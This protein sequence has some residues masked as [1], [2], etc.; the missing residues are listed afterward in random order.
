[1]ATSFHH[2]LPASSHGHET[3]R[4]LLALE[5]HAYTSVSLGLPQE[6]MYRSHLLTVQILRSAG[7]DGVIRAAV[8][9]VVA[10][11][12]AVRL[13]TFKGW[14][15]ECMPSDKGMNNPYGSATT[16]YNEARSS[17][18]VQAGNSTSIQAELPHLHACHG[19]MTEMGVWLIADHR[20]RTTST[21]AGQD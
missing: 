4:S 8:A 7:P 11:H 21:S 20:A 17:E 15:R 5:V 2:K 19:H 12:P 9:L 16:T 6:A 1:M 3:S 13:H 14:Q 10:S 18:H